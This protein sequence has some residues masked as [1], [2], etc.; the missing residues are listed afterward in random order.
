MRRRTDISNLLFSRSTG[1]LSALLCLLLLLGS[2]NEAPKED[3]HSSEANGL[4]PIAAEIVGS[5][6]E[7]FRGLQIGNPMEEV[8]E[9]E[10]KTPEFEED[11]YLVYLYILPNAG[12]VRLTYSFNK[13][14]LY[15]V[16]VDISLPTSE[17]G[18]E[19]FES[20]G[21]WLFNQYG[22]PSSDPGIHTWNT[23]TDH[24]NDLEIILENKSE[25][26][27]IGQVALSFYAFDN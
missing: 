12:E 7:L 10:S 16:L 5:Q 22:S 2:C 23:R 26:N 8:K 15:E 13:A 20:L 4:S 9:T 18:T 24:S 19:V 6:G 25:E 1:V 21:S 14:G 11:D 27:G 3:G 17:S